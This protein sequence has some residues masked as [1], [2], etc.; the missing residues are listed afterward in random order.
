M[1]IQ[2]HP[3]HTSTHRDAHQQANA[4]TPARLAPTCKT[5]QTRRGDRSTGRLSQ[6]KN[7][8]S[9]SASNLERGN[10]V[11]ERRR[12]RLTAF[13]SD[14]VVAE[15]E[16]ADADG[17]RDSLCQRRRT[18]HAQ[19]AEPKV[20]V[21]HRQ[22]LR[23]RRSDRLRRQRQM[24]GVRVRVGDGG[25]NGGWEREREGERKRGR[26]EREGGSKP[27]L[28]ASHAVFASCDTL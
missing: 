19:V 3:R 6:T 13:A 10:H 8:S 9:I 24:V 11:G 26:E 21:A 4:Y 12:Q 18:L 25:E 27:A 17:A 23:Q 15:I 2:M 20:D 7:K 5:A 22:I 16:G 28:E 14:A 1:Q